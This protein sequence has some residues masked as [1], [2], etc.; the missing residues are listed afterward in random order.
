VNEILLGALYEGSAGGGESS[1]LR[2]QKKKKKIN[3]G[4]QNTRETERNA[5][6]KERKWLEK[7]KESPSQSTT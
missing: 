6:A 1:G 3:R 7:K 2:E 4:I 5:E